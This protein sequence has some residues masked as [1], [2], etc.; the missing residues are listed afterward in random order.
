MRNLQL[1]A[2]AILSGMIGFP[3]ASAQSY[4]AKPVRIINPYPA[5]GGADSLL[6]PIAQR[7][8]ESLKA[9]FVVDNRPGANGMIGAEIAAK[10]PPDGYTLLMGSSSSL[11]MNAAIYPKMTYD[12]VKDFAPI[13]TFMYSAL[14]LSVHPSV[15]VASVK[16]FIALA[17]A[18]PGQITCASFGIASSAHFAIALFGLTTGTSINHVPYKGSAPSIMSLL[19]GEVM[20]SF[21]TMQNA[22]PYIKAKRL[23]ALGIAALKRSPSEPSIPTIAE[24]GVPGFEIGT[25]FG[26]LA[27]ANTPREIVTKLHAEIVKAVSLPDIRELYTKTG[28]EPL[29]N[30]PEEF[31]AMI[32][33]EVIKWAKVAREANIHAE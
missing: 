26:V 29:T 10:S 6:R 16:D 27:P 17:K 7:M 15:P 18:R 28:A 3:L 32:Q 14:I 4:P 25:F 33:G 8:T 31:A 11:P 13:S 19:A 9:T 20:S 23:R 22:M 1:L 12:P 21:D 30:T 5:G 2:A 24:T